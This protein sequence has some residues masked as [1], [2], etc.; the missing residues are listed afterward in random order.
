MPLYDTDEYVARI[1]SKVKSIQK[2][3]NVYISNV[4]DYNLMGKGCADSYGI[5]VTTLWTSMDAL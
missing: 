3:F 5:A 4:F 2:D 1:V